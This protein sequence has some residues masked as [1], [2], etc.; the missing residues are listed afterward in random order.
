MLSGIF[1]NNCDNYEHVFGI[2]MVQ[3][4][5]ELWIQSVSGLCVPANA[6]WGEADC[7]IR[8]HFPSASEEKKGLQQH[9]S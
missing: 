6:V 9:T 5:F 1:N 2:E 4:V 3:H 8:Y 7:F